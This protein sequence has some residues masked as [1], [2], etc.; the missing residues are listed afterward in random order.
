MI[1]A[2]R[3]ICQTPDASITSREPHTHTH[4]HGTHCATDASRHLGKQQRR[5]NDNR[6]CFK[7]HRRRW[8]KYCNL[9]QTPKRPAYTHLDPQKGTEV[10]DDAYQ[11]VPAGRRALDTQQLA[12]PQ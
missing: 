6:A 2:P 11:A 8:D 7:L 3:Q 12:A 10:D 9:P 4:T 1:R 5:S